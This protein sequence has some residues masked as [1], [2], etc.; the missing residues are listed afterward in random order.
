MPSRISVQYA[1]TDQDVVLI[2][3]FLCHIAG[4]TLP[5]QIDPKNSIEGIWRVVNE[6]VALMAFDGEDL[7]GTLG[8]TQSEFW[9][10][11]KARFLA[12]LW[13]FTLPKT[14]AGKPLLKEA[15]GIAKASNLEL[16]IISEARGTITIFN[17]SERRGRVHVSRQ[18]HH[19]LNR[20][21]NASGLAHERSAG[22]RQLSH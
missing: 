12:N 13:F 21:K 18:Q 3:Q 17:K 14:G 9:W 8:I 16:H 10:G 6:D 4:P 1:A 22:K 15:I 2:H 19:N 11:N 7:V 5:G 20:N